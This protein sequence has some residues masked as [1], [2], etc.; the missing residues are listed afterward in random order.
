MDNVINKIDGIL[1]SAF[2]LKDEEHNEISDSGEDDESSI[3]DSDEKMNIN[4]NND[5]ED[6]PDVVKDLLIHLLG[7]TTTTTT[8]STTIIG[9]HSIPL[10]VAAM[11][12]L[13]EVIRKSRANTMMQL[14][15]ELRSASEQI[16][17]FAMN[18]NSQSASILL[19]GRS[20]IALASGCELFLK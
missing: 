9:D 14:E 7:E 2:E 13:L 17:D 12:C 6:L 18:S 15:D 3:S 5:D 20:S 16:V 8:T 11:K 1:D 19:G 10:P 4:N